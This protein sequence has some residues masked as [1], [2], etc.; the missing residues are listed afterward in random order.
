MTTATGK[1]YGLGVR[2][3]IVWETDDT[4][5]PDVSGTALDYGT[6]VGGGRNFD[7]NIPSRDV[8]H[9]MDNDIVQASDS[10]PPKEGVTGSLVVGNQNLAVF[11]MLTGVEERT[12]G[13]GK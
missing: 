11:S 1:G 9:H 3:A 2:R 12:V 7:I 8:I 6:D 10:L 4:G 5:F 13:E